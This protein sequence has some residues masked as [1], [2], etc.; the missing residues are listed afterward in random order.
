MAHAY[1]PGLKI[2]G[3]TLIRKMR[4]L[5]INGTVLVEAGQ[6]VKAEE[7]VAR[8]ELPGDVEMINVAN[9][10]SIQPEDIRRYMLKSEGDSVEEGEVIAQT[11]GLFGL[12]KS[13]CRSK[14]SGTVESIS[15]VTGQVL[16]R[17]PP[18]P[19]EIQAYIDGMVSDVMPEEGAVIETKGA[20]IQ[21][22]F[23]VGGEM[24]GPLKLLADSPSEPLTDGSL[25]RTCSGK[26]IVGGS[27]VTAEALRKAKEVGVRG[28][29]VG[30][31]NDRDLRD[32]LGYEIGVAIT[33]SEDISLTLIITEGFG[34][35][36]MSDRAFSL[37][38]ELDGRKASIN[39]ATQIRAGVLR[40]E[41]IVP[42][43]EVRGET[44]E[45]EPTLEIGS[46]VRVIR[47]PYFGRIGVVTA[48]PPELSRIETE[49][50]VRVLEMELE[51]GSRITLPRANVEIIEE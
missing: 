6:K 41:V 17:K 42:L 22:I 23:G 49:S 16:V 48:L 32:F 15:D 30:G 46:R 51:D 29:I 2:T 20:L 38:K 21:G 39:G 8:T 33:G 37:L 5:P 18:I 4:R 9:A 47:K 34:E 1:T 19:L 44:T 36:A 14:A 25:D 13:Q 7:S 26:I 50:M 35:I 43:E 27:I 10:L 45:G 40:P 24:V 3:S 11:K 12:F 28:I 31:I